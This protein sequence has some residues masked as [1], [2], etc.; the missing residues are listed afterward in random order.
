MALA[1]ILATIRRETEAEI[2]ALRR[3]GRMAREEVLAAARTE[4]DAVEQAAASGRDDA[5]A[6]ARTRIVNRA[7]LLAD[8]ELRDAA[9]AIYQDVR[10]ATE[11]KLGGYRATSDYRPFL[12]QL[13]EECLAVLPEARAVEVDPQDAA[14]VARILDE[15]RLHQLRL[16]PVLA[17]AGGLAV[18]A[19]DGRRVDNTVEARIGRG[20]AYLR[21]L[22]S[23]MISVLRERTR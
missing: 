3:S 6:L 16:D 8:R 17:T 21:Q 1:E 15:R 23:A 9:E 12:E 4:A 7:G 19:G 14:L 22:T 11:A 5:A 18:D 10:T 20:E 2:A 13:L